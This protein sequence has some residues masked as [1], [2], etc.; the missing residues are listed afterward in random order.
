MPVISVVT[1]VHNGSHR[2]LADAY[3][4]LC[5]QELPAGWTWQW[6]V[7]EDGTSGVP[8]RELPDDPRISP[9]MGRA[10]RAA[11]ARTMALERATGV[12][13]RTLDSDDLLTPGALRRDIDTITANRDIGWCVSACLDL[14]PDG[15]FVTGPYDPPPGPLP[16]G[17]LANGYRV[18]RLAVMGTTLC[19]YTELIHA[20]GGWQ[21]LP[22]SEDV[23]LL[24]SCE[25]V[26]QGWMIGE[27]SEIYRK[28]PEQSTSASAYANPEETATRLAILMARVDSIRRAGWRWTPDHITLATTSA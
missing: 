20:V 5:E 24:V 12:L 28:H 9:G 26:S 11:M 15:T 18:G 27:V 14:M 6:V 8:L 19:A 4:S 22:A 16:P 23:A 10:G 17:I 7:Q 13:T 25:A 21:A 3:A 1:A 2:Y